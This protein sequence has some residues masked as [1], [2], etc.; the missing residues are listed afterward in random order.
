M[1]TLPPKF[2]LRPVAW[3]DLE[4]V[5]QLTVEV[6][7]A[8][9]DP[10]MATTPADLLHWWKAPGFILEKDAWVV[11]AP[12][13]RVV[14]YEEFFNRHVHVSLNGDGYVHPDFK[15]LGIGTTLL[16]CLDER[17]QAEIS[18]VEPDLRVFIRNG[19]AIDDKTAREM[20]EAEG[21]RSIRFSW[22]MEITLETAPQPA[23]WPSGVELR[24]YDFDQHDRHVYLAHE[25][26]FR[27]HW[28][29]TPHPYEFWQG[30]M[31]G[32]EDFDPTL[33]FIAW[34][35]DEV[36]GYSLCRFRNGIGWVNTL[37][38]RRAW[39]KQGL[40]MALLQ[41]SFGEFYKRGEKVIGLG[42]D[43]SNP[44]GATRLYE[45]AGMHVASEFVIYEKEYRAG[46]ELEE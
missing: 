11:T 6:C 24:P 33:W 17:A 22:R 41:H 40:G 39:R 29:H 4:A 28:G 37:G 13:G 31:H 38:V 14:G 9:G 5:A 32:Q 36:A 15:G 10:S 21:Y 7:T 8:E 19:M 43:A 20:H 46:R 2:T 26:A 42:V 3:T 34:D 18:Q 45:R 44:T 16:R 25:E 35:G 30:R 23:C 12:D 27:D 1:T